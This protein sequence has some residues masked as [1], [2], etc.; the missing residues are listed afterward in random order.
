MHWGFAAY[1]LPCGCSHLTSLTMPRVVSLKVFGRAWSEHTR[2]ANHEHDRTPLNE[3]KVFWRVW[4]KQPRDC[5]HGG[6]AGRAGRRVGARVAVRHRVNRSS[7][8]ELR[9]HHHRGLTPSPADVI[10]RHRK[11]PAY[12]NIVCDVCIEGDLT[13][14]RATRQRWSNLAKL[15]SA[16]PPGM[17][18]TTPSPPDAFFDLQKASFT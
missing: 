7:L 3:L 10:I 6:R 15:I 4:S 18:K 17:H 9:R 8:V 11:L 14:S 2:V 12:A 13:M 16:L 1:A 5:G